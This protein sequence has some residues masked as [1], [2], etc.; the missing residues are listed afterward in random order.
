MKT[1]LFLCFKS[2]Y[3]IFNSQKHHSL[4]PFVLHCMKSVRIQSFCGPYFPA[5]GLNT[6]RYGE[7]RRDTE[8]LPVFILNAG[9]YG[10]EKLRIRTLFTQCYLLVNAIYIWQLCLFMTYIRNQ[11]L[12]FTKYQETV[13]YLEFCETS[14]SFL[15]K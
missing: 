11:D 15:R 7:I 3:F 12:C 1:I 9:K 13:A 8:Y 6:E 14:K 5:F 4:M 10:P 2:M